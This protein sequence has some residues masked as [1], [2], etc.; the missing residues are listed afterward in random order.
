M[1]K[2]ISVQAKREL[3]MNVRE[4]YQQS[5]CTTKNKI[6]DGFMAATGYNR[7]YACGLLN[8][9]KSLAVSTKRGYFKETIYGEDVRQALTVIWYAA[10]QIYAQKD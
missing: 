4:Q 3:L 2:K 7:K 8:S 5:S 1:I 10:N 6:L 9:K